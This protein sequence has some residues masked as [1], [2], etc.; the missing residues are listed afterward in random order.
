[1]RSST[2]NTRR[3]PPAA[4]GGSARSLTK[5]VAPRALTFA[6]VL[7]PP[8]VGSSSE[9]RASSKRRSDRAADISA[10]FRAGAET[11]PT[12][13]N[14]GAAYRVADARFDFGQRTALAVE[15]AAKNFFRRFQA[16]RRHRP[17]LVCRA[18][19][20]GQCVAVFG[21][22][23]LRVRSAEVV[24]DGLD[25]FAENP[26]NFAGVDCAARPCRRLELA[27]Q[28]L[29]HSAFDPHVDLLWFR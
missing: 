17:V 9:T 13:R 4:S 22:A 28:R 19:G 23:L 18:E 11:S 8:A 14:D 20:A 26:P 3:S 25:A 5:N 7:A 12:V 21:E 16:G 2:A 15:L 6:V 10:A 1:A 29:H 27:Q 24:F